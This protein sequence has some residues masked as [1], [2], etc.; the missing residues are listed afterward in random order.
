[1]LKCEFI[2]INDKAVLKTLLFLVTAAILNGGWSCRTHFV[3]GPTQ[4]PYQFN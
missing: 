4:G 2:L 1:M 3:K